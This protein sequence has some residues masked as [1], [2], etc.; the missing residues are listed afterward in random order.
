MTI[1][2]SNDNVYGTVELDVLHNEA[3]IQH[4]LS[5]AEGITPFKVGQDVVA[6]WSEG[7][8]EP[9]SKEAGDKSTYAARIRKVYRRKSSKTGE[10]K[11]LYT[12]YYYD[13][14]TVRKNVPHENIFTLQEARVCDP[15]THIPGFLVVNGI[16]PQ[17]SK[18]QNWLADRRMIFIHLKTQKMYHELSACSVHEHKK[19][20][21]KDGK[22][23]KEEDLHS[24]YEMNLIELE[25]RFDPV[26][27]KWV[28]T[29]Q[30]KKKKTEKKKTKRSRDDKE[31]VARAKKSRRSQDYQQTIKDLSAAVADLE[32]RVIKLEGRGK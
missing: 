30:S 17:Y 9:T 6:L 2:E 10:K 7:D 15:D 16:Y 13:D 19:I 24:H 22:G 4:L 20:Y 23:W 28:S 3:I 12:V 1:L 8:D 5:S 29:N 32:K 26:L 25:M 27:K 14:N 31:E 21:V 11:L 18:E